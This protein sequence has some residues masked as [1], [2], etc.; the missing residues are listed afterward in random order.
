MAKLILTIHATVDEADFQNFMQDHK[1][2]ADMADSFDARLNEV[3]S[4]GPEVLTTV[5][6]QGLDV[7]AMPEEGAE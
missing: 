6:V 3:F 4:S 1:D 5:R 2:M 7:E